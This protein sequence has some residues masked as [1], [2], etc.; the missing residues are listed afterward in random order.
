MQSWD[1]MA[2]QVQAEQPLYEDQTA[3]MP[4]WGS[5]TP[6]Q[7]P[8]ATKAGTLAGWSLV[9]LARSSWPSSVPCTSPNTCVL[10]IQ[11]GGKEQQWDHLLKNFNEVLL[12]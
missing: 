2:S 4:G 8:Q 1:A 10:W 6:L 9:Y 11:Q 5:E 3:G 12:C 7:Q